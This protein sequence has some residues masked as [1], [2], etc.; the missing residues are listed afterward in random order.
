[1][2]I[3]VK[4][5]SLEMTTPKQFLHFPRP[6]TRTLISHG[7]CSATL[8]ACEFARPQSLKLKFLCSLDSKTKLYAL[9]L[10]IKLNLL[11]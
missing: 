11:K 3:H 9:I 1:M 6:S 2:V 8:L 10:K 7:N 5:V 4:T